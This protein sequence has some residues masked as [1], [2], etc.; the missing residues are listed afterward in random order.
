[1]NDKSPLFRC[2]EQFHLLKAEQVDPELNIDQDEEYL[3]RPHDATLMIVED[4]QMED[5]QVQNLPCQKI[6]AETKERLDGKDVA[7]HLTKWGGEGKESGHSQEEFTNGVMK[8]LSLWGTTI[9]P[10]E[11][12]SNEVFWVL[13][14]EG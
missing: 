10:I 12:S 3:F 4:S 7:T 5:N 6:V 2:S 11:Q 9:T 8:T 1:M 13:P 14:M